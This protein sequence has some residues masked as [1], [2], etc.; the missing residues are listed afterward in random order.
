MKYYVSLFSISMNSPQ[1]T[2]VFQT[3]FVNTK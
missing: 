1:E 3:N 2:E